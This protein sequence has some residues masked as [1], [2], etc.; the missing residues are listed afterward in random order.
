[1]GFRQRGPFRLIRGVWKRGFWKKFCRD[2]RIKTGT[3]GGSGW[4]F[5]FFFFFFCLSDFVP[6]QSSDMP[7]AL[8]LFTLTL[9]LASCHRPRPGRCSKSPPNV[10]Y[11]VGYRV[12]EKN[13]WKRRLPGDQTGRRMP[14]NFFFFFFSNT[15]TSHLLWK[16]ETVP[17][18]SVHTTLTT[19]R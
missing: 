16:Q 2:D 14:L 8:R 15:Q 18:R 6:L 5:F 3:F 19:C 10:Q 17:A 1:M 4:R 13:L 12:E 7:T 9:K 11:Y